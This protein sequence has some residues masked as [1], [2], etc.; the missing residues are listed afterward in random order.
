MLKRSAENMNLVAS[1]LLVFIACG[2]AE[3]KISFEKIVRYDDTVAGHHIQVSIWQ[4]DYDFTS[5]TV[6]D[7]KTVTNEE[8]GEYF[9]GATI[10]GLEIAGTDGG[11]PF[12]EKDRTLR[13]INNITLQ[14]DGEKVEVSKALHINLFALSLS[15][16]QDWKTIQ[17]FPNAEGDRLLIQATGGDGGGSYMVSLVLSKS[18]N[19]KQVYHGYWEDGLTTE[20]EAWKLIEAEEERR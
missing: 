20:K 9:I 8:N 17:F 19:H 3:P 12:T 18:G 14:W 2:T 5:H 10:D 11:N 4:G 1:L 6:L 15:S 13:T 7:G 16:Q